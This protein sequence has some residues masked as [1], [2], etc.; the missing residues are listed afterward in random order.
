MCELVVL[1]AT[2]I[3][4]ISYSAYVGLLVLHLLLLLIETLAHCQNV[5]RLSLSHRYYFGI[6]PSKLAELVPLPCSRGRSCRFSNSMH[7][8][9]VIPRSFKDVYVNSILSHTVSLWNCLSAKCF[10]L[11][12][13]LNGFVSI[14]NRQIFGLF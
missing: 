9:C 2:W 5:V 3:F 4:E 11:I 14:V 7:D 13:C 1:A 8:F 12:Y 10:P 6:W